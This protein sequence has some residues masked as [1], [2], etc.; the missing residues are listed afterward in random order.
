MLDGG[1]DPRYIARRVVRMAIED[2]SLADPRATEIALAAA[3][4][5]E[6]LGSPEGELALAQAVVYLAVA[7]KSNAVY[8]AFNAVRSFIREDGSRPVP[9]YLRNAPTKL[10]AE[11]GYHDGYRYAH[12]EPE[13]F[14]A[15]EIYLPEGLESRH[16]YEPTDRGL[17]IK[18]AE[19]MRHLK[20]LNRQAQKE[21]KA[22]QR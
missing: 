21:G 22:R 18:I 4:I 19:K 13:A 15:G 3:D 1:C 2:V 12:D 10:M 11:L 8:S 17:E 20:E 16:W 9:M 14:A 7:P 5:Y 6:R